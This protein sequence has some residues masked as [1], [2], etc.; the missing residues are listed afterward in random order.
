MGRHPVKHGLLERVR[1]N[2]GLIEEIVIGINYLE[3][4][5]SSPVS[6]PNSQVI[7]LEKII[8]GFVRM[9]RFV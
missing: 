7:V 8:F 9:N 5:L 6:S 3:I 2:L 1:L 4:D